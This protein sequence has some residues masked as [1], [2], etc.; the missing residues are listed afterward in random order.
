MEM[1]F[2]RT[3]SGPD[4]F[5]NEHN[6]VGIQSSDISGNWIGKSSLFAE[7]WPKKWTKSLLTEWSYG[8]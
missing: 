1:N 5:F 6:T 3:K 2:Y 8:P 7:W 4:H